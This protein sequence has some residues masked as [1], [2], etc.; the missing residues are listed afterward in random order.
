[1]NG[2]KLQVIRTTTGTCTP[3]YDRASLAV[4]ART[5]YGLLQTL[6]QLA[7]AWQQSLVNAAPM[8]C[9]GVEIPG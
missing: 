7:S 2:C 9:N 3:R 8:A 5:T 6:M 1:M 4:N